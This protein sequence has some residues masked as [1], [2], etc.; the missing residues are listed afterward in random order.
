[1]TPELLIRFVKKT[2]LW[3]VT[4]H[5][6]VMRSLFVPLA[7]LL[8]AL[9]L[10]SG[11]GR[12]SLPAWKEGCLDIH[13]IS[14]GRGECAFYVLPDGTTLLVDAGEVE[15]NGS[16]YPFVR[17]RPDSLTRPADAYARYIRHFMPAIARDSLDYVLLTHFHIDHMGK[18]ES[19]YT[20]DPEG[21]FILSG[22]TAVHEKVPFRTVI[23][24]SWPDYEATASDVYGKKTLRN[25][26]RF[27]HY[28]DSTGC[29]RAE[30]FKLGSSSQLALRHHPDRYPAFRIL[31]VASNGWFWDG[32]KAVDAYDRSVEM[33]RENGCSCCILL[34][35]GD[36]DWYSGGDCHERPMEIAMAGA[37][38]RPIE[39]MKANH[40][41]AWHTM[42]TLALSV[43]R[44]RV[45]VCA[46][47]DSHKPDIPV[48]R[49][50]IFSEAG[51]SGPRSLYITSTEPSILTR[52]P[53]LAG[54]A[55]SLDGH[56]VIR[57]L[58]GGKSFYVYVLDDCD[59]DYRVVKRDGPFRCE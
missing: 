33:P 46:A 31:N 42:D 36:F 15:T 34:R 11:C 21:G 57:V 40:H 1:M 4:K 22:I 54:Q 45:I 41:L 56:V 6:P 7:A 38:G 51:Y 27:M 44:P 52:M 58:P 18:L 32:E 16:K 12:P 10:A 17:Q 53:E 23:D 19:W 37:L 39:A 50:N 47:F 30:G 43:V 48:L 24:R 26:I 8:G 28:G 59:A 20:R 9:L 5:N 29:F 35:Y 49:E 2:Y 14:T 55:A 13:F 3:C 25:W